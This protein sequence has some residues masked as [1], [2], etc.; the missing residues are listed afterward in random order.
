M[1]KNKKKILVLGSNGQLGRSFSVLSKRSNDL[2]FFFIYK[3]KKN[4]LNLNILKKLI[5]KNNYNYIINCSAYTNVESAG[6]NRTEVKK[7]IIN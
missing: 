5:S 4:Y 2:R 7:L 3:K 6:L 1:K